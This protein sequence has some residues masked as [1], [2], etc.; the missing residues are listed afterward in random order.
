LAIQCYSMDFNTISSGTVTSPRGFIAGAVHAGIKSGNR[1]DLAV[2]YSEV[3][4]TAA[5]LFTTN[6]IKSAPVVLSQKH[7]MDNRAQAIVVNSGCANA[8]TGE[9]GLAD[10]AEMASLTAARLGM[11]P[12][13]V[14]AASTGVIGVPLPIELI[15]A[16]IDKIEFSRRGGHE[17]ARA[18]MTTDTCA[19]EIAISVSMGGDEFTIAGVAKGAGMIHPNLA[20]MLCFLASDA[21]VDA[22]FLH[23]ALEKAVGNSFNMIT[24]DGDTSPSDS[25]FL[26]ANE[27]AGNQLITD[28][29][30]E[31]FQEGLNEVCLYLAKCIA[32]DGEG[33]TKLIEV[34]VEGAG[35]EKEARLAARAIAGSTL[36]KTAMHGGNPNWGRIITA[37]GETDVQL[38]ETKMDLYLN[39]V[40]VMKEGTPMSLDMHRAKASLDNKEILI[41]LRLNVGGGRATAWGCDL[42]EEYV[43]I[44]SAYMT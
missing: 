4:C 32:A 39:D 2:F 23:R 5:G 28:D 3:P 43:T 34:V 13:D 44:N 14:L 10:A 41:K 36:V 38:V 17:L 35:N 22:A 27:L 16:G 15:R 18:I 26:L 40:C 24:V 42:S 12:E 6:Q 11:S 9:Q 31:A 8:C 19:K 1:L 7:L 29:N 25:V 21:A 30:G 33:A 20:T 37:L